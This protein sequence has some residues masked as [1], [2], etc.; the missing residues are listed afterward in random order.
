MKKIIL[1][2]I[3]AA[4]QVGNLSA[5]IMYCGLEGEHSE[6]DILYSDVKWYDNYRKPASLQS[7][8]PAKGDGIFFR[9][10][11]YVTLKDRNIQVK[12]IHLEGNNGFEVSSG[13]TFTVD[14]VFNKEA[15]SV[16]MFGNTILAAKNGATINVLKE[17]KVE[18]LGD[19]GK[20]A[21]HGKGTLLAV[22][23]TI[24]ING[25]YLFI[26]TA[27][28]WADTQFE[29]GGI[30]LQMEGNSKVNIKGLI[31]LDQVIK[32]DPKNFESV[33]YFRERKGNFPELTLANPASD[34]LNSVI[35]VRISSNVKEGKYPLI[36]FLPKGKML[37][38]EFADIVVNSTKAKIGEE[39][40][41]LGKKVRIY[42][43]ASP[44]DKDRSSKNDLMIEI[45]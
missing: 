4:L 34:L 30:A 32:S 10:G 11:Y 1:F 31:L 18:A 12:N 26:V 27:G 2:S 33:F 24:N 35:K 8:Q 3:L 37:A 17:Y 40:D 39:I 13:K 25:T 15:S 41:V 28:D 44:T 43:D 7:N 29:K 20:N 45:K 21:V 9:N 22:D 42:F 14:T 16:N 6:T 36:T 5:L 23:S 38:G 19:T